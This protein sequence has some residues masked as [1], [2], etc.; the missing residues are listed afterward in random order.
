LVKDVSAFPADTATASTPWRRSRNSSGHWFCR[1]ARIRPAA[2][3]A[4]SRTWSA[5]ARCTS[6]SSRTWRSSWE[7]REQRLCQPR[8]RWGPSIFVVGKRE[9]PAY[10]L[11]RSAPPAVWRR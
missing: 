1:A 3:D 5:R 9:R 4:S 2:A 6:V 11:I 10:R 8:G 7:A